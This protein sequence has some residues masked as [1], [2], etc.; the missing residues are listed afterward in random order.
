MC[1]RDR[2]NRLLGSEFNYK[3]FRNNLKK[4]IDNQ[5][6]NKI[7]GEVNDESQEDL[8]LTDLK[9]QLKKCIEIEDYEKAA[10]RRDKIKVYKDEHYIQ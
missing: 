10:Q 1:I 2:A 9:N 4:V 8:I 6:K 5:H 3:K 7:E